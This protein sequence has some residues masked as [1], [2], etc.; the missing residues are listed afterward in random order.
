MGKELDFDKLKGSENFHTWKFAMQNFLA[1]KG[2]SDCIVHR[3]TKAATSTEAAVEYTADTAVETDKG[4]LACAKAYLALGVDTSIYVHIQNCTTALDIWNCLH[5]LYEDKGLYRKIALLGN[6]LSN[7]L[8]DCD[9]MQDYVDKIVSAANKLRGVGFS[10]NDEWLG[11]ILLSGL[12][13][14]FK[15]FIMGLEANGVGISGDLVTAKLLDCRDER[16]KNSAFLSKKP[17]KKW[18][19]KQRKCFNCSSESHLANACNQPKEKKTE[20][21]AKA[22]FMMGFLG[23]NSKK[24]WYVDSGAT[25]HMTPHNDLLE[26][27]NSEMDKITAANGAQIDVTGI[28]NGKVT[29]GDGDV[30]LKSLMHVPDLAVNLLSVSQIV[31]NGNTVIFNSEGCSIYNDEKVRVLFCKVTSGVYRLNADDEKCFLVKNEASA[32]TWHR[33]LGHASY[34]IMKKMRAGAVDGVNFTDDTNEI[35]NCET[36]SKGKQTK[37]SFKASE[38]ESTEILQLIHSDLMG[39]QNTRSLGH[40]LYL[41]TFIDDYSRKVFVY[42]LKKKSETFGKFVEFKKYIEKQS[43]E[44]IKAIRTDGGGEYM[45]KEMENFLIRRGIKH[46]KTI[47]Y[48]PQQ[49]GVAERMNRSLT[50]KAKCFLFDADLPKSYW[51]E[52]ISMAAYVINRTPCRRLANKEIK[53]PEEFFT[54]KRCDLS[55]LKLFG[56]KVMVLRPRQTRSKWDENTTK[57]VFVGYDDCVKGLRC[58]NTSNRK[59]IVSRNVKF[60]E[61]KVSKNKVCYFS[62]SDEETDTDYESASSVENID[63]ETEKTVNANQLNA[64]EVDSNKNQLN[65]NDSNSNENQLNPSESDQNIDAEDDTRNITSDDLINDPTFN[66]RANTDNGTRS[67]SRSRTPFRPYQMGHFAFL[68]EPCNEIEPNSVIEAKRGE[69]SEKWIAAMNEEIEAHKSN[70]TWVL[71]ELPSGRKA[72]TAK[73]VF[74][75]KASGTE[76]ERFKAR[77]VARGYAQVHGI[78]YYETFSPV[79]RHTSLRI[80]FALGIKN[81]MQIYQMDAVTAFLQSELQETIYMKQPECYSDGSDRVCLLKKS[82]YGL[83]QAGR[84][85]NI[86]LNTVLEKFNLKRSK[87]DPCVHI[88]NNLTLIIAVYVDDLLIF[89]KHENELNEL[90]VFLNASLKMKEIG[91]AKEC[92]GIQITKTFEVIELSQQKYI[93]QILK[94]FNMLDCKATK[95]PGNP[96]EKLSAKMVSDEN[97]LTGKVPYQELIGSLL[98]VAQITRPDIAFCVN[99]VSR[100]NSKHSEEHWDAALHI[101]RY[102]KG[103]SNYVLSFNKNEKR[104]VHA[105]SDADYASETDKRRSC[106]GFVV[107]LADAAISW[108]SK[109]QE[110]VAVSSTEAEY[111]ALSTTVKETLWISQFIHELTNIDMQPVQI[112]CD[113]TSTIKLAK[114]DAYRERT[115]HIDVRFHHI[116]DNIEKRQIA[117]DFISTQDM[118]A[119]VLTKALSGTKT[120][121]FAESMGLKY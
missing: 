56:S 51:A 97:D 29:F 99:N 46:E 93:E 1:L 21:S 90:K 105:Y 103:T 60:F 2:N 15:P 69:N 54:G 106:T 64:S 78:D 101:L 79:V 12:T 28:G 96:N 55:D 9:G 67:S 44:K 73:W 68:V 40:A 95:T 116:R 49:N 53:T 87:F 18:K 117:I 11:A 19:K 36:C 59:I 27:K 31:E 6:L 114:T 50:E 5:K 63:G 82:I 48:T 92:I 107:K 111:I 47:P 85:W 45:S 86:K 119:D 23:A 89:Y 24:E 57:M 58:V 81:G 115:K 20:K 30:K 70:G 72:I 16:D 42:F 118:V 7:K 108:H 91:E 26:N 77:L 109:R 110:I 112:Y 4:K 14:E 25:R 33:R 32:F 22:A 71:S 113:N 98:Y 17:G 62:D 39:P 80:M 84:Q 41:L 37:K 43:G 52:A 65:T 121:Q 88:N 75:V 35:S 83:K 38:T 34:P 74:K 120:K 61:Q 76:N 10:V 94:R 8:S 13:E 3:P 102:L 66:T 100:F 104:D